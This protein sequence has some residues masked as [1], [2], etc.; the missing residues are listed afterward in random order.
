[1]ILA[2]VAAQCA[3][4]EIIA[5]IESITYEARGP[6][7]A[8]V[9]GDGEGGDSSDTSADADASLD[10]EAALPSDGTSPESESG[11]VAD[12]PEHDATDATPDGR[13][14]DASTD[15]QQ[16]SDAADAACSNPLGG[17]WYETEA[18][19]RC[20]STWTRQGTTTMFSDVQDAPC[21]VTAMLNITVMGSDVVVARTNSSDG[22]DCTYTGTFNADCTAVSGS[23]LCTTNNGN[24]GMWSATIAP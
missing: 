9:G 6:A 7:D 18:S 15:A 20:A 2:L 13:S 17:I 23:Y 16:P 12:A 11:S 22:N 19:G 3:G 5:G 4:C 10:S 14:P 8:A 21:N 1:L 24:A